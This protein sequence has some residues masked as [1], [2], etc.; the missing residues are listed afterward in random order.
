MNRP[1]NFSSHAAPSYD[2][3]LTAA[4]DGCVKL[5]DLR[6][7]KAVSRYAAHANRTLPLIKT[8]FSP[9]MRFIACG[10]EDKNV[11]LY[12]IVTPNALSRLC[13][14]GIFLSQIYRNVLMDDCRYDIR[15]GQPLAVVQGATDAA[16]SVKTPRATSP[17]HSPAISPRYHFQVCF[18]PAHPV[19]AYGSLDGGLR[20]C[21]DK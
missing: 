10:G 4:I 13:V 9:C 11:T 8:S 20:L 17:A 3:F 6:I 21:A 1:S 19:M 7:C 16:T 15:G 14:F 5:W 18:H 12:V 2:L